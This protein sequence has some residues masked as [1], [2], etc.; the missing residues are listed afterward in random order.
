MHVQHACSIVGHKQRSQLPISS[1]GSP[2]QRLQVGM[3]TTPVPCITRHAHAVR[4]LGVWHMARHSTEAC[5]TC[6]RGMGGHH[7]ATHCRSC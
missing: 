3:V 1:S 5:S 6:G 7:H 4:I 2:Y